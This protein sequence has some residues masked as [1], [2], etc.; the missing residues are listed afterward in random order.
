LRC[1]RE[2]RKLLEVDLRQL[3]QDIGVDFI[4]AK[5]RLVLSEAETSQPISDIDGCTPRTRTDHPSVCSALSRAG[6]EAFEKRIGRRFKWVSSFSADFNYHFH[7]SFKPDGRGGERL[8]ARSAPI[9]YGWIIVGAGIVIT[10]LGMGTMM[11][12]GIFLQPMSAATGWSRSSISIAALLNFLFMGPASFLWGALSDRFG[13][14]AVVLAGGALLGLGLV[15]ASQSATVGEF[16]I[17]FGMLVGVAA[18]SFYAP[19]TATATRWFTQH[20]SLAVALIS[21]GFAIGSMTISP[22]ARWLITDYGWRAAMLTL[23]VLS[24]L[25]ILPAA[26]LVRKPPLPSRAGGVTARDGPAEREFT[27]SRALCTPQFAAIA[28]TYFACCAAH[29]GPIFHMVSYAIDCGVPAMAAATVFGAAG[30]A[31]LSGRIV[32][33]LG[34]DRVGAKRMIVFGLALQALSVSLYVF[35]RDLAG[36]YGLALMFG[37]SYGAVMPLYAILV[38]EYFGARIMG[39]MFGAVNMAS[40]LGMALG[41]WTGGWLYDTYGSYFWLYIGSFGIGLGAVAIALTFRPP[42]E[43]SAG[44]RSARVAQSA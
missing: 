40:T 21:A 2:H 19:L 37:F 4:R 13:T 31:S 5:E 7:M 11:S 39:T 42:R 22:M 18:G 23:G 30:I 33:G 3:R 20:R 44:L 9:F 38:R 10:C 35:T 41:P 28:F 6:L 15:A 1:P 12:L 8:D 17:V 14:R 32:G 16:Q 34:A 43:I 25:F 29:S 36:F 24:W 27:V 26:L